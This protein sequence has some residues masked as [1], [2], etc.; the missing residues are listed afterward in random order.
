M[1][2]LVRI[3]DGTERKFQDA[4]IA[5]ALAYFGSTDEVGCPLEVCAEGEGEFRLIEQDRGF[6]E[7]TA[8]HEV[9]RKNSN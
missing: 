9:R 5:D 3:S 2:T 1:W 6:S 7:A 8:C 4:P